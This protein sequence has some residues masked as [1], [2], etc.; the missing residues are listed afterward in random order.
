MGKYLLFFIIALGVL[1]SATAEEGK[2]VFTGNLGMNFF[3]Y[4]TVYLT[5]G[6]VYQVEVQQGM[7]SSGERI[8]GYTPRP[9]PPEM[10]RRIF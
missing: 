9:M 7:D 2:K 1:T 6:L 4:E 3:G 10:S 8:S 5:T